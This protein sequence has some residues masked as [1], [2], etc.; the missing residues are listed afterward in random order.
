MRG[1]LPKQR[2]RRGR[3]QRSG[4]FDSEHRRAGRQADKLIGT[5]ITRFL[6]E[7]Q[8][9]IP[10]ATGDLTSVINDIVTA[11]KTIAAAMRYGAINGDEI[12]GTAETH[13]VQGEEQNV[14]M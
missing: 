3:H 11:C 2:E 6:M 4:Q 12:F 7:E 1:R 14:W 9:R 5:T 10:S 8:R 13:N